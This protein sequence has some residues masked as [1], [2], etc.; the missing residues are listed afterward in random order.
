MIAIDV[1]PTVTQHRVVKAAF[2]GTET[3]VGN[4]AP[5]ETDVPGVRNRGNSAVVTNPCESANIVR[6]SGIGFVTA[7][8]KLNP[9]AGVIVVDLAVGSGLEEDI[10]LGGDI[11]RATVPRGVTGSSVIAAIAE[12]RPVHIAG[13]APEG[14]STI[15]IDRDGTTVGG[16]GTGIG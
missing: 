16:R 12:H 3:A 9:V 13:T 6:G 11:N 4:A 7:V 14:D 15:R 2:V 8:A 10:V 1:I 5:Q